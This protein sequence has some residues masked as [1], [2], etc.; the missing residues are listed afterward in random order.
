MGAY[1][2]AKC[3]GRETD[4]QDFIGSYRVP[5]LEMTVTIT[6]T[7]VGRYAMTQ[8]GE[9]LAEL[10]T[11]KIL[12]REIAEVT[13][14]GISV[15]LMREKKKLTVTNFAT[16]VLAEAGIG[17]E[18]RNDSDYFDGE[19]VVVSEPLNDTTFVKALVKGELEFLKR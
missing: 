10:T 16:D 9:V 18:Y 2:S 6:R 17:F 14:D 11:C 4:L 8:S 15:A 3:T 5:K 12:N 1:T 13:V 19:F 7:G